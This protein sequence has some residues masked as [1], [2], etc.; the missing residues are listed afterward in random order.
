MISTLIW[1]LY[2]DGSGYGQLKDKFT[3]DYAINSLSALCTKVLGSLPFLVIVVRGS[4]RKLKGTKQTLG[5]CSDN[6]TAAR[7]KYQSVG[8][9]HVSKVTRSPENLCIIR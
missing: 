1:C 9:D 8:L 5:D 6:P 2:H 4:L 3:Q 7:F